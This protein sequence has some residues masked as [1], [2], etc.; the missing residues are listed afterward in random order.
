M[1]KLVLATTSKL[2]SDIM[3]TVYLKHSL[4]ASDFD[5]SLDKSEDV[6]QHVKNLSLGKAKSILNKVKDSIVI[7]LDT[8]CYV[9]GIILEKPNSVDEAREHIKLCSDNTTA[10]ITGLT[11]IN[12]LNG[13]VVNTYV[14]S[15]VTMRPIPEKDIDFYIKYE[16]GYM[17]SSGFIIETV[18]SNFI[19]KIEGSYYNI[20]GVPVETI[21]KHVNSWGYSLEDL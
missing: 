2:K 4:I 13:E 17:Y 7:G 6:Y 8:V 20:L 9:D 3:N 21:Y 10:V 1:A 16:P 18:L 14:E 5:E 19:E 11:I 15:K 12:Q